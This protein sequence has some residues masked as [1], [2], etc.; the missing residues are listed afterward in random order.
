MQQSNLNIKV[1]DGH[2]VLSVLDTETFD[3]VEDILAEEHDLEWS[4]METGET[5]GKPVYTVHFL[6]MN[7]PKRL[8]TIIDEIDQ[9]KLQRIWNLNN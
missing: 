5:D 7:D 1:V 2:V 3:Y 6:E 9:N 8:Q 4:Y